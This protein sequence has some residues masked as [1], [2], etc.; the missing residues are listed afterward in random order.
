MPSLSGHL[1]SSKWLQTS[2]AK[3]AHITALKQ[4]R[5]GLVLKVAVEVCFHVP[6]APLVLNIWP[7]WNSV[8]LLAALFHVIHCLQNTFVPIVYDTHILHILDQDVLQPF[9]EPVPIVTVLPIRKFNGQSE[10]P[11]TRPE[12][13]SEW[14]PIKILSKG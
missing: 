8:S 4:F 3:S 1:I 5:Q 2:S 6:N 9:H 13:G 11:I 10:G 7:Q 12:G 14:E